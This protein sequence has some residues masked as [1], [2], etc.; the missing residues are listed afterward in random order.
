MGGTPQREDTLMFKKLA[1]SD[2]SVASK[3]RLSLLALFWV[4]IGVTA[5]SFV[6]I[7]ESATPGAGTI[8]EANPRVTW[9]G[10]FKAP[11]GASTCGGANSAA[12]D[13]FQ[14]TI[15][16]PSA[17]YGPYLVEVRLQPELVGDWDMQV[18]GPAGN[19]VDGSGNSPG[20]QELVVLINPPA[21]TYTVAAAPFAP[22]IGPSGNSFSASAEIKHHIINSSVQ[23]A[24]TNISYQ[25]FAAPS[26]LGNSAGE[27]TIGVNWRTG[28][29]MF[30]AGLQTLRVTF[31]DSTVPSK[32][33]WENKSAQFTAVLTMD[34]I[35][36]TDRETGRTIVSQLVTPAAAQ[37]LLVLTDGCSIS[38]YTDDDGDTWV[39]DEGCG[40]P[41][42]ADHQSIGGGHFHEPLPGQLPLPDP[43]G[44]YSHAT[45]YCA[46][47]GV[48]AYCSRSD[49]GGVTY[50]PGVPIYT[51]ECGGLHGH[52]QVAP[53]GTVYVPN[54]NCGG[55]QG[56]AVSEDNG[57]T[58]TV[59]S[60]PDTLG[61][62]NDPGVGIGAGGTVY[63]GFQNGDGRPSV[64]VSRDKGA[65]WTQPIDVGG[66]YGIKNT[67]FPRVVAGD[68]DRAAFAFLGTPTEG[69]FQDANFAGEWHLYIAHTFDRGAHWTT[70]DATPTDPVQRG[71]IWMQGGSNPCRNLLDFMGSAIDKEGRVL[72]GY[73]DGCINCTSAS[74]SRAKKATIARQTNGRRLFAAYDP[75]TKSA[76]TTTLS[77]SP[78][79]SNVGQTVTFTANVTAT[80]GTPTGSIAFNDG[81]TTIGTASVDASGSA[82]FTT[83]TLSAGNHSITAVYGGDTNFETSA[84]AAVTQ[85]VGDSGG[86]GP[87]L[88]HFNGNAPEDSGCTGIGA[89]DSASNNCSTLT[90]SATLSTSPAAKW[91]AAAGVNGSADRNIYDPNWLWT[92]SNPTTLSGPM[93]IKWWQA[94]NA[95]CVALGGT[96][97]IR[98]WADGVVVYQND[99]VTGTPALPNV[100]SLLTATV[101]LP[102]VS[103]NSKFVLHIDTVFSDTG[104]GAT[105]YY[106]SQSACPGALTG[107]CDST[108]TMPVIDPNNPPP[109][110]PS[111]TPVPSPQ[112]PGP[113]TPRF[114]T[115]A[116]DTPYSGGEPSIGAN[117]V[118]GNAMYLA[119]FNP[120]RISF[121]DCSSPANDTWTNTSIPTAVSL[122]PILFT[123]H[124]LPAGM[125][126]RT[127][128]SQLTGQ[129]SITFYTDDDG[130][131]YSPSQG[132]GIPSG[133]DH[134]T[135]GA[136]PYKPNTTPSAGP[137]GSY[138]NAVYYCSQEAVTAFCARSDDGGAT[139]GA[140]V[141]IYEA[142]QCTGIHGHVKVA[143]D[144]TVYV[145]NRSCGGKASVVVSNDNG[146]TWNVRPNPI[147]STTGFL[148]DPSVG[149]GVNN[150]GKPGGQASN[151]IYL[152]Y[153]AADGHPRIAVS[154][155]QGL[156]WVNDQDVGTVFGI[157]NSTFPEVVAG[158]DNRAAYAFLGT[159]V[160]GD[161]TD[162]ATF[163]QSAPWHLYVA[164]TFDGGLTWTTADVTPDDPVQRGSICNLGT[165]DCDRSPNDRNLLDFMDATVDA[166]G[167]T[168]VAYPDGC[169]GRC[170]TNPSGNFPNSYTSRASVARQSGGRRL[171]AAFD[172]IEPNLP[173][174]PKSKAEISSAGG[175]TVVSWPAT[176][177]GGAPITAYHVFRREGGGSFHLVAT[178]TGTTFSDNNFPAP[179]TNN[180]Y[181]VTAMNAIG[182]GRYCGEAVPVVVNYESSCVAPYIQVGGE[183]IPGTVPTDP[184]GGGL[185]I[186][187]L[188][189]GEPFTNCADNS[190]SFIM[191]VK[192]FDAQNTG[193]A[194]LP[195]NSEWHILFGVTDTNGNP[196]KVF[197]EMDTFSPD[198]LVKPRTAI[199]RRDPTPTGTQDTRVCTNDATTVCPAIS[200]TF[201]KDGTIVFKL[202]LAA[203]INFAAPAAPAT[204]N[205][206]TWDGSA[207]GTDIGTAQVITGTTYVL[208]GATR[209]LLETVQT[210][211]GEEYTRIGNTACASGMPNASLTASP[212]SGPAPLTVN[213]DASGSSNPP[214]SCNTIASYTMDFG[215]GSTVANQASPAFSHTYNTAG[216]YAARLTVT[217]S[218]GRVS[219]NPAQVGIH[220][221]S[222]PPPPA[223][224]E[225]NDSRVVYSGGWHLISNASASDGH[226]RYHTGNSPSHSA[227]LDFAVPAGSTGSIS[228]TFARSPKGGTADVY[229]DGVK[230]QTIN[231]AGS[232][233]ST[234]APEF[235]PGYKVTFAD[236]TAGSHKL[237]IKNMNGVVYVDQFCVTSSTITSQPSAGPGNTT[238]Q[239]GSASAGQTANSSYQPP[240]GSSEMTVTVESTLNVPFKIA[241]VNPSGVTLQTVDAVGG[242][243]TIN[244]SVTQNG[245]YV[246]KV[247]NVSLGPIQFTTTVTPRV[248]R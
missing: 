62:S 244:Q 82:S 147:S 16:P 138:P 219:T 103:A 51:T 243:A 185:T 165:V 74:G 193:T 58:W 106:D 167:R 79:P 205:A 237:E 41:A 177:N 28:R 98:L 122:D 109:P 9:T 121:D 198:S 52:P 61:S 63:L 161:Y 229:L 171:F 131:T 67:A 225:D 151:T 160:G 155:D 104:Q 91:V 50:G 39:L 17:A 14:L 218:G 32:A 102:T 64:A 97:R 162:Q 197:L 217:D 220:V 31:D 168:L 77:S 232:A 110:P 111:P 80:S 36:F 245:S 8:S 221:T 37:S 107:P 231:Y 202:N 153:Q 94:C 117:W 115:Y 113:G 194:V 84:S 127:F 11:T 13:N 66:P 118:T 175:P 123:D 69:S 242:I 70:I 75:A 140:G 227:S 89:V 241:I 73:A 57:I 186:E 216:D 240:S 100:P 226:F 120:L 159:T 230:K 92:L 56:V 200:A 139:F 83:S 164:T 46:Q 27:P 24:D 86:F 22:V 19:L 206:F 134:Q 12:C 105:I 212:T 119:S 112:P 40:L 223:C 15:Q 247:V 71:C 211:S 3:L 54:K 137:R 1:N 233:G 95:E 21:G 48:T 176:D 174:A 182:E 33:T 47:S 157:Q 173:G 158:D 145:P 5:L 26:N 10:A 192:T 207:P 234:Q 23:G 228:Y 87:K 85:V 60:V 35:L 93:T 142:L 209:G 45:Y 126:N 49:N 101:N 90:D 163:N 199:G 124:M 129:D 204:G 72:I 25:N 248:T 141:P 30:I 190:L 238:N 29:A 191:K 59:R 42:G 184:T 88:L 2:S 236:L 224:I 150:V 65:N 246:I 235:N 148:V 53:D 34:P 133:V 132:G 213:F 144:G 43:A 18:Y 201:N 180:A 130:A 78:N 38:G 108:V 169:I 215:D 183:G 6:S 81:G 143:P 203:P 196:Q 239:S 156:T 181:R 55:Q 154:H 179:A 7:S 214:D 4:T 188:N 44:G 20:Q 187:R 210:T 128:V 178:V 125:P 189:V 114:Q 116:P 76:T 146:V 152:G 99:N 68:D 149:I 195:P 135:L 222:P 166:Q 208:L 96:W 170:V 136:G 172:P